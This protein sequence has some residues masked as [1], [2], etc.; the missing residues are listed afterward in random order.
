MARHRIG[1]GRSRVSGGFIASAVAA[2]LLLAAHN[3][4]A[5]TGHGG[6]VQAAGAAMSVP[7]SGTLSCSGLEA[8][9]E[10]AGGSPGTAFTAAEIAMAESSGRQYATDNNSNGSVD[11]GYWQINS[12]HGGLSTYDAAGNAR[13]AVYLSGDG[14]DWSPW[15]TYNTGAYQRKC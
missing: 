15:V 4:H 13:A 2:G 1:Y 9:W 3:S 5:A 12:I 14:A 11:R 7:G 6:S 8:L 10:S